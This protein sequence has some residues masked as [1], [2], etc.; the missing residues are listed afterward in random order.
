MR[1]VTRTDSAEVPIARR[2]ACW[3]A[4]VGLT[5]CCLGTSSEAAER[6]ATRLRVSLEAPEA[7]AWR[8]ELS[9]DGGDLEK[10]QPLSLEPAAA[11]GTSLDDGRVRLHHRTPTA[12]DVFDVTVRR[13]HGAKLSLRLFDK[14]GEPIGRASLDIEQAMTAPQSDRVGETGIAIGVTRLDVDRLRVDTDRRS[15]IFNPGETFAFEVLAD[16]AGV[17]QGEP[18]DFV[19]TLSRGRS[20]D[21]VWRSSP[22]RRE[23]P[24]DGPARLPLSIPLPRE[25]GVYRVTLQVSL[26]SGFLSRFPTGGPTPPLAER[27]F[28][29]AVVDPNQRPPKAG[30]WQPTYAF[31]PRTQT[32]ADR[33]PDWMRWRRLPWFATGPLSSEAE[34]VPISPATA[35]GEAHWRAYPLPIAE[36]GSTYAVEIETLGEPGDM[37]TVSVMEPDALGDLRPVSGVVTHTVPRWNR[38]GKRSQARLIVRPRTASPLLVLANPSEDRPAQFGKIRLLKSGG[39][40]ARSE[41]GKERLVALDWTET[42]LP[43][44]LGASHVKSGLGRFEQSDLLTY[45]ETAR[46]LAERV[47]FAGANAAVIPA[48]LRGAAIYPSRHWASPAFDL[49]TWQSGAADL[50]RRELLT[51]V[52]R[53][54][55]RRGLRV[56]PAVRFD[57]PTAVV[58]SLD[59]PVLYDAASE[60]A[61]RARSAIVREL[62]DQLGDGPAVAGVMVRASDKGWALLANPGGSANSKQSVEWLK[63]SYAQLGSLT[64]RRLSAA[65]ALHLLPSDPVRER[66][67]RRALEPRLGTTSGSVEQMIS[68]TGLISLADP[69]SRVQV[70]SPFSAVSGD[71]GS[72]A[73]VFAAFRRT[74][75]TDGTTIAL[76]GSRQTV[77]LLDSAQRLRKAGNASAGNVHLLATIASAESEA[78]F[79]ANAEPSSLIVLEGPRSAGWVAQPSAEQLA[80]LT[81][82]PLPTIADRRQPMTTTKS[83]G[84]L[85]ARS[86]D[87]PGGQSMAIVVNQSAWD[88]LAHVTIEIPRR[89]RGGRTTRDPPST[90]DQWFDAGQHVL[91][92]ELAAHETVAW[93]FNGPGVRVN[94]VRTE[95][96]VDARRELAE[97]LDDLQSRDTTQRRVYEQVVNPSF[98]RDLKGTDAAVAG[99]TLGPGATTVEETAIDGAACIGL[100]SSDTRSAVVTSDPF[101]LPTTGQLVLGL[102]VSASDP[103]SQA[104]LQ[105]ELEEVDGPYRKAALLEASQLKSDLGDDDSQWLPVM[106]PVDDLPLDSA[107]ELRLRFTLSGPGELQIDDLRLEDLVLPLDGYEA[108]DL[109]SERFAVVRLLTA[110]ENALRDGRL[111]AC[112]EHIESYWAGFLIE[113]F[114]RRDESP[115]LA[116][117]EETPDDTAEDADA[118]PSIGQRLRG[119]LPRWW[120]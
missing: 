46:A 109:R 23:T 40:E 58:E 83:N 63:N 52:V 34:G 5:V 49:S 107:G 61:A 11:A 98:E 85:A 29:V 112:R 103:T 12:R 35:G 56:L 39:I 100:R 10:L 32:W 93:Q 3:L 115:T 27:T 94:G 99:W 54:F 7:I 104:S 101:P 91:D 74:L 18:Y 96:A 26:P 77:R 44:T 55:E 51:M 16:P 116:D 6:L 111:E 17:S 118:T 119:Y 102:Q 62:L 82:L 28:Q 105:I 70:A 113:N 31:D 25:E 47:E 8:G 64:E 73:A 89:L 87:T 42:D 110:A 1:S 43:H 38:S 72:E 78:S 81:R 66:T 114:P 79:L 37:L 22:A 68:A 97:A 71:R 2:R 9:V 60:V 13:D 92:V 88:R 59:G 45:R 36:P 106:F 80:L 15:L 75:P 30:N 120:R 95:P 69:G 117:S 50:P 84:D 14:A 53:E 4:L 86:L 20:G 21:E 90:T 76:R 48:N 19:A 108:V 67:L 65:P 24:V 33:V 57:A 41:A